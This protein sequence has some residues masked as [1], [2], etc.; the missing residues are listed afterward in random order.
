MI[1]LDTETSGLDFR[2]G[3]KPYFVVYAESATEAYHWEW[4][5]DPYT[6]QP[7]LPPEELDEVRY[8]IENQPEITFHNA[9]F[10]ITAL[11]TILPGIGKEWP[12][13]R[14]HDTLLMAHLLES[15]KQ[16]SLD[17]LSERWLKVPI[18]QL[19]QRVKDACDIARRYCRSRL[20]KWKIATKLDEDN[21]SAKGSVWKMDMWLP[22]ALCEEVGVDKLSEH[23]GKDMSHWQTVLTNYADP[24]A[25]V[26]YA[27]HHRLLGEIRRRKLDKIYQM[28]RKLVAIA[29]GMENRGVT[30]SEE[31][32][33]TLYTKYTQVSKE[34]NETCTQIAST[35]NYNLKLP[36]GAT[37]KNLTEFVYNVM[38]LE[39]VLSPKTGNP[40]LDSK[41]GIP[42]YLGDLRPQS[43]QYKF[44]EALANKRSVDTALSFM[45]MYKRF[46]RQLEIFDPH[47]NRWVPVPKWYKLHPNFKITATDTLRWGCEN[48]TVQNISKKENFNLRYC[49][50]PAPGRE[51]WSLDAKNIELRLPF[52]ESGEQDLIVLFER[53]KDPP[54]YG[55]NHLA[56]FHTIYPDIW[57]KELGTKCHHP[58]C[59]NGAIVD[60][61]R[62]G[63]HCKKKFAASYYQW[64]K[65][66]G[67][68]VQYQAGHVTADRAAHR[69][70]CHALLK[71]RFAKLDA[72]NSYLVRYA[73]IHGYVETIPD[74]TVDPER[75]YPLLCTKTEYGI[76]ST[77]PLSYRIQ[78]SAMWWTGKGMIRCQ[79]ILDDMTT[80]TFDPFM[81]LQVHDEL[82]FDFPKRAHPKKDPKR[83]NLP[84]I[85]ELQ[86]AMAQG[87][88]DFIL[89]NLPNGI[90]TPVGIEYHDSNWSIGETLA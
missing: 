46:W 53:P 23:Y 47:T 57:N 68:A 26:T 12:W 85:L 84:R 15:N 60:I 67:F 79:E 17:V 48:P 74:R 1:A 80:D 29:Y 90:P 71:S 33:D 24:D 54:Y 31:H 28:R 8:L 62:I 49:F 34:C 5:V 6:R 21:P 10:D 89:K 35:Y 88:N 72:L 56:N 13:D 51:W 55:S 77:T 37:N 19:E 61:T 63:P 50:G 25:M 81:T 44:V 3:V 58:E 30:E 42:T 40:T 70:G 69:A 64:C 41:T 39:P 73:K 7:I 4:R 66:F 75:G 76:K 83:S 86:Q 59:C 36:N 20:P 82:V 52:Y 32:L 65:N 9:K 18:I 22:R 27:L 38:K 2:H 45:K 16:K 11:N 78:G 43:K 14:T 87:G